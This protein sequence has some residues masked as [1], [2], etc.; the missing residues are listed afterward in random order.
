MN[1]LG[2]YIHVR[3]KIT[4]VLFVNWGIFSKTICNF[5]PYAACRTEKKP[6]YGAKP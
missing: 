6:A 2:N 3:G 5:M 1:P 4:I